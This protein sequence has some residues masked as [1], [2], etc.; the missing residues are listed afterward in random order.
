ME[1]ELDQVVGRA[2]RRL[3]PEAVLSYVP[4]QITGREDSLDF[5]RSWLLP[6]MRENIQTT[7]LAFFKTYFL[8]LAAS[9]KARS[10]LAKKEDNMVVAKPYDVLVSQVSH[11]GF[12]SVRTFLSVQ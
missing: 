7:E 3:G 11:I 8:P 1:N 5:P 2:I 12:I 10:N 4:L 9:C 6:I